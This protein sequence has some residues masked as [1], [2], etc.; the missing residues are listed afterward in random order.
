MES[1]VNM[2]VNYIIYVCYAIDSNCQK[3]LLWYCFGDIVA[4]NVKNN[5][6]HR[7][8]VVEN[9]NGRDYFGKKMTIIDEYKEEIT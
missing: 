9:Q 2:C 8:K 1:N 6:K 3:S 5:S 7:Y 4:N